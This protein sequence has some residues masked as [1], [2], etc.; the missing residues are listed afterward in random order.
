MFLFIEVYCSNLIILLLFIFDM[1]TFCLEILIYT[2]C[3]HFLILYSSL[4]LFH[5]DCSCCSSHVDKF[6]GYFFFFI[7]LFSSNSAIHYHHNHCFLKQSPPSMFSTLHSVLLAGSSQSPFLFYLL[8]KVSKCWS[9][10][11][12]AQDFFSFVSAHS[13]YI[14]LTTTLPYNTSICW[15]LISVIMYISPGFHNHVSK[16]LLDIST[17]ISNK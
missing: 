4:N 2:H 3:L 5:R 10:S 9:A 15:C 8:Y 6:D 11:K 14:S 13:P 1:I 7:E 12:S 16:C 17:W